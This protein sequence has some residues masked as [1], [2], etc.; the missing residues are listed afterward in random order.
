MK[1]AVQ[2]YFL[3]FSI[4]GFCQVAP[5]DYVARY[6]FT[7][8]TLIN[9]ANPGTGDLTGAIGS[10]NFINDLYQKPNSALD[11]NSNT[12]TGYTLTG[13]NN[14]LTVS[15]WISGPAPSSGAIRVLQFYDNDGDGMHVETKSNN[16]L[17]V[18]FKN[19]VTDYGATATLPN[20]YN[21]AWHLL[22]FV[23]DKTSTGGYD[24]KFYIDGVYNHTISTAISTGNTN[25]FLTSNAPFKL[26]PVSTG[27]YQNN[28]DDIQVFT[29]ALSSQEITGLYNTRVY[30]DSNATGNNDGSSW[31]NAYTSLMDGLEYSHKEVFVARGTY[32]PSAT[33][34]NIS[35]PI[36]NNRTVYGG[37]E[38]N[39]ISLADRDVS[40]IHTSN[41]TILSGDLLSNDNI[42]I[43]F[44]EATRVDNSIHVVKIQGDNTILNGLT[45]QDGHADGN[46]G[47]ARFGGGV[48][49]EVNRTNNNFT[50]CQFK[51]NVA[52][53]G[54]A[55]QLSTNVEANMQVHRCIFENNLANVGAGI[56]YHQSS[57]NNDLTISITNCLFNNNKTA[58]NAA[59]SRSGTGGAAM[60]LRAFFNGV[61]L[62]ASLHNN[63]FTNN[64]NEG[65]GSLDFPVVL[66]YRNNGNFGT[67]LVT[68][69]IFWG[70][71]ANGNIGSALGKENS[72][73]RFSDGNSIINNI[74]EHAFGNLATT[75]VNTLIA[76][77]NL[78]TDF[79]LSAGSIAID[80]GDN[81]YQST[82]DLGGNPRVIN[83]IIDRGAYEFGATASL[84]DFG[85]TQSIKLYP[86]PVKNILNIHLE[87][88]IEK[89]EIYTIQG[90]KVLETKRPSINMMQFTAGIYILKVTTLEGKVGVKRFIKQ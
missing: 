17:N 75:T 73:I 65:S 18:V 12:R 64:V 51:N 25:D 76:N 31:A 46:T 70:N 13:V 68:N 34:R 48:Y 80:S 21:G 38:G 49:K 50:F 41:Q 45:V 90:K 24:N 8:S 2:Y 39:E 77:P 60:R 69:N 71:T 67:I 78:N 19:N 30:V 57:Q 28:V 7:N 72:G 4:I 1:I 74:D 6:N 56:D 87:E 66:I 35:F 23:V 9:E 14:N 58:D 59:L 40:L 84:N 54:A 27:G 32:R 61:N 29:R 3:F 16:Q 79:T 55:L 11:V 22:T 26:S 86:N 10:S 37:F 20:L 83:S 63:T 88:I 15:F 33:D 44:N 47:D 42:T 52:L 89:V 36:Y 81:L 43:D 5:T 53:S 82:I 85:L 62:N